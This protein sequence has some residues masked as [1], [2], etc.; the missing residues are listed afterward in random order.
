M[1]YVFELGLYGCRVN[2]LAMKILLHLGRNLHVLLQVVTR[3][4]S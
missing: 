4:V 2:A 1:S 3:D